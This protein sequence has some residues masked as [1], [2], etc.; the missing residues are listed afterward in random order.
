MKSILSFIACTFGLLA[1]LI[2]PMIPH[3]HHGEEVCV[4]MERCSIDHNINDK[5]TSHHG[6]SNE[7]S[8]CI[9]N[10]QWLDVRVSGNR[11]ISDLCLLPLLVVFGYEWHV[12]D[13]Q[14]AELKKHFCRSAVPILEGYGGV[15]GLRA[16]PCF[17]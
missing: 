5:H 11:N 6:E 15:S 2:A 4:V 16:P 17:S 10:V 12:K 3:H 9:K 1:M 7:C 8:S 13:I 14:M